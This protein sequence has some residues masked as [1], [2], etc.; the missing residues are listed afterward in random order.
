ML[1]YRA[2]IVTYMTVPKTSYQFRTENSIVT[3]WIEIGRHR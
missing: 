1:S 2:E 3:P